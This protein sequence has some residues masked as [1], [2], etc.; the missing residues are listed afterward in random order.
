MIKRIIGWGFVVFLWLNGIFELCKIFHLREPPMVM[1]GMGNGLTI[2]DFME[3]D[4]GERKS[5]ILVIVVLVVLTA[6]IYAVLIRKY[7]RERSGL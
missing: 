3:W 1:G 6:F 2:F 5:A 7:P 4:L